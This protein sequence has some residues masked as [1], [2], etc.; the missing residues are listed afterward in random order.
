MR[1]IRLLR[2]FVAS[3]TIAV[4]ATPAAAVQC[5]LANPSFELAGSS[6]AAFGGWNQ[7]GPVGSSSVA[8][9]GRFSARV[10]GPNTHVWD[11]AGFWQ[12]LDCVPGQRWT[13]SVCVYPLAAGPLTGGSQAILNIEWHDAAGALISYESH[14]A[15][16]ATTPKDAWRV[17]SVQSGAAPAGTASIHFVLGVLQGPT[18]PVPT[19]LFDAP[20]CVLVGP[21]TLEDL[22]WGDFGGGRTVSFSGRTWRV[23]GP[24][25]FGPGPNSFDNSAAA[26]NVD[27]N[28]RLHLTIH[29]VGSTWYSSEVV[30]N[31]ALGYGD[32][33]FTTRGR[34]D[35]LDKNAV[36]GLFLWQYGPCYD[37]GYLWW[38]PYNEIDVEFSR[39][40][41]PGNAIAQF[42]AQ[43]ADVGGNITRFNASFGDTEITSHAMR[44][45]PQRV[46]YRSWRGGPDAESAATRIAAWTY[47]GAHIPRPEAPRVHL[48]LWQLAAPAT[49]QEAV[50]DAFTFRPACP[51]GNCGVLGVEPG[52]PEAATATARLS[53]AAPNPFA[54]STTIRFALA[55]A[56]D[57]DL[58]VYDVSGRIV[59]RLA[60]GRTEAGAHTAVWNGRD[61]A[62]RRVA[63]GVYLYR[64]R[65]PGV[66]DVKRV[67]VIE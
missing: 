10:S 28:G 53:A 52:S 45:L 67:V 4:A 46:E 21:P 38:N 41:N 43:P 18:D 31:D 5:M 13:T 35:L 61:D 48:N 25:Y 34:L 29:K 14:V 16:D 6:G 57:V 23:K 62:G 40:G 27:A 33:V 8:A 66:S 1:P 24:G 17:C 51:G 65:A 15:A 63:P 39:W 3:L 47:T 64:L 58:A 9:H 42:V 30:L 60:G 36:L 54:A 50:F 7:F 55:A 2:A 20:T 32:Y 49:A 56:G 19:V 44:W 11:V 37:T 22:Q 59:R 12:P 26:A